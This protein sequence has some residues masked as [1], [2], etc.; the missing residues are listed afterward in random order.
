MRGDSIRSLVAEI[1]YL[2]A[3]RRYLAQERPRL[4]VVH[5]YRQPSTICLPGETIEKCLLRFPQGEV[6]IHLSDPG[7]MLCDCLAHHNHTPLS[8]ARMESILNNAPFYRQMG[9]NGFER[10]DEM[11]TFTRAS[12]RVYVPRLREQIGKALRKGGS[13]L[14][15]EEALVSTPTDSN[16]VLHHIALPVAVVHRTI[17]LM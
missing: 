17:K 10:M 6:P 1:R 3:R 14:L 5:G 8:I 11:P 4:E 13:M 16:Q 7:R 12:L 2:C 15:P 9:A